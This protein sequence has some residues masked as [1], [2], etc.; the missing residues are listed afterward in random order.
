MLIIHYIHK[1]KTGNN[2]QRSEK[3]II[4]GNWN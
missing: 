3:S 1:D 4:V 2:K